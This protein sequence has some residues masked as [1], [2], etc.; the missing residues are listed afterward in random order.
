MNVQRL[1]TLST[2]DTS[3]S[4]E[5]VRWGEQSQSIETSIAHHLPEQHKCENQC[6]PQ[7]ND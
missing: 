4:T 3:A 7:K 5:R 2:L 6:S 1:N